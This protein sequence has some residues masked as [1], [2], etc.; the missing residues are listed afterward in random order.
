M[1]DNK[2]LFDEIGQIALPYLVYA[3]NETFRVNLAKGLA[4][5]THHYLRQSD[6]QLFPKAV[7]G[8]MD[9]IEE[10]RNIAGTENIQTIDMYASEISTLEDRFIQLSEKVDA[11]IKKANNISIK[12][13]KDKETVAETP[14]LNIEDNNTS[15]IKSLVTEKS[16]RGR[17][18]KEK[19][20]IEEK[21][22]ES[23][24][25]IEVAVLPVSIT[26]IATGT[27]HKDLPQDLPQGLATGLEIEPQCEIK[28][29]SPLERPLCIHC[30]NKLSKKGIYK[31]RQRYTCNKEY[32]GCG[33]NYIIEEGGKIK[34]MPRK[35][36]DS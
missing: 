2:R 22:P 30:S 20:P 24:A 14:E 6:M 8:I 15:I 4:K 34:N 27:C 13:A 35:I 33:E 29:E 1:R 28:C 17:P 21:I 10:Y 18:K 31:G 32:G 3:E 25:Q 19:I 23:I 5:I 36:K 7:E 16:K 9:M 12:K 26:E 11:F